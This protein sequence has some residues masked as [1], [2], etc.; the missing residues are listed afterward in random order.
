MKTRTLFLILLS[1]FAT[2][3]LAQTTD[4]Q[5]IEKASIKLFRQHHADAT[6]QR[7]VLL[8]AGDESVLG[9]MVD[10]NPA[11][12]II[13]TTTKN[14]KP[15]YAYSLTNNLVSDPE[16]LQL[17]KALVIQDLHA[18]EYAV[19]GASSEM[20]KQIDITWESFL[21]G[22]MLLA[23]F[24][25]WPPEGSTPTEG[26]ILTNWKQSA[27]YYNMCPMDL[28][29]GQRSLTGCPATAMAQIVNYHETLN[30]TTL[31]DGDD[32]YHSYAG[33]QYWIDDDHE[34]YMFPD[35]DSLNTWLT[36]L[37]YVYETQGTV[38]TDMKAALSFACG[39]GCKS[40]YSASMS[41]TFGI[42]QAWDSFQRFG[43]EESQVIYPTETDTVFNQLI[44][45]NIKVGL[46]V[47]LGLRVD[48]PGNGGHNVVADGYNTD[49]YY[50]F[51]FGWG[52]GSNGWYTL[53]PTNIAYNLT[54]IEGAVI[55]IKSSNYTGMPE[56]AEEGIRI[57]PNPVKNQ[58][59]VSGLKR[60]GT[61][62]LYDLSGRM[63]NQWECYENSASFVI[64]SVSPGI[65]LL[66]I[67]DSNNL[68]FSGK[69]MKE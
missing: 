27:P 34:T 22:E 50:H 57:Y 69:I 31:D 64:G 38:T 62:I 68:I 32:Y 56:S 35:W 52:G 25:Q 17:M 55:D 66:K 40:V 61:I 59:T 5:P 11:G 54:I 14:L 6:I 18:R 42:D 33:N 13:A 8:K 16:Q 45:E 30:G 20:T 41:G 43:F 19:E 15:V 1:C 44:A 12:F 29:A 37:Q 3:L 2:V 4:L 49:E 51:N 21:S 7:T 26:W 63:V 28:N 53:P 10:F 9:M 47:Q 65:Y 39:V 24:Q 23:P 36:S 48:P 58:F 46:P 67:T 60:G